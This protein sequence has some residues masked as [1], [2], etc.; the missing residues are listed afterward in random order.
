M[1]PWL[2]ALLMSSSSSSN[3]NNNNNSNHLSN[4]TQWRFLL[5]FGAIPAAIVVLLTFYEI[6]VKSQYEEINNQTAGI[7]SSTTS[8]TSTPSSSAKMQRQAKQLKNQEILKESKHWWNLV[9]T[10]GGWFLY[11]IAFYG[12]NLFGGEIIKSI[13]SNNTDDNVSSANSLRS[14]CSQ[15]L[16][17]LSLG[18]PACLLTIYCLYYISTRTLQGIGF[19]FI[20]ICFIIMA[21]SFVPLRDHSSHILFFVYCCLLFSLNFG[22]NVTTFILP[23]QSYPQEVRSTMNGMSAAA[24]K[25]G[26]F[27]GVYLFGA[28]ADATSYPVVMAVCAV[29]SMMGA[30]LSYY[31][32]D[33][34]LA[35]VHYGVS[36]NSNSNS[37]SSSKIGDV[38]LHDRENITSPLLLSAEI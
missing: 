7:F 24:G 5:G 26:A 15:E 18:I 13:N 16:I 14:V 12:V 6:Q 32:V 38:S 30:I 25:V 19:F 1:G 29:F 3:N 31:A 4:E 23:A 17:G 20:A 36:S 2:L 8:L 33:A 22:P 10:G 35:G 34:P 28:M 9:V 11:D 21:A 37:A 27:I